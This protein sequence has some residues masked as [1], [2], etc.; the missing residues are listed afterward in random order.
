ME[1][2]HDLQSLVSPHKLRRSPAAPVPTPG[3]RCLAQAGY[4]RSAAPL[5]VIGL[6]SPQRSS[7][8]T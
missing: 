4:R 2:T 3:P 6:G 1:L 5:C 8:D 7:F